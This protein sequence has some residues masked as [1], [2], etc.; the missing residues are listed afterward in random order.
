MAKVFPLHPKYPERICWGCDKYCRDD[1]LQCGNGSI[2]IPHPCEDSG[3]HWYRQ[4]DWSN[5]L[6]EKQRIEIAQELAQENLKTGTDPAGK[7]AKP[8][9]RLPLPPK[10]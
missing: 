6:T 5:L 10:S 7:P 3:P 2:R 4:G 8:H 1:D 9:I